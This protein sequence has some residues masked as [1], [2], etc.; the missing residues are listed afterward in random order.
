MPTRIVIECIGSRG[1]VEPYIALGAGLVQAGYDVAVAT[2]DEFEE[3]V[4]TNAMEHRR[5]A[6]NPSEVV[7]TALGT[8]WQ[9]SRKNPYL[10]ASRLKELSRSLFD[11]Y[12][13]DS[14]VAVEDADAVVFSV[15]GVAAYHVAEAKG[16]PAVAAWLQPFTRTSAFPNP[17]ITWLPA[18]VSHRIFEQIMWQFIRRETNAFRSR[19]GVE[20]HPFFGP[21]EQL[22][23]REM[24]IL[25]GF[26]PTIVPRPADWPGYVHVTGAW[27]RDRN[28]PLA[29]D[30]EAF[31]ADGPPPVYIGFGS[32][33]DQNAE[34]TS[35]EV[36][37]AL[38]M[39]GARAIVS[40]GWGGLV[41]VDGPDVL[42]V[43]ETNHQALFP[44]CSAIVHHGGAGTTHTA[45]RSGMPSVVVPHWAD[46]FFWADRI[47]VTGAGPSSVSRDSLTADALAIRIDEA[48]SKHAQRAGVVGRSMAA[49]DGVATAVGHI[50][51]ILSQA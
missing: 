28:D 49:E 47:A 11:E 18:T 37:R 1:D 30:L 23:D 26:S 5:V 33:S 31:L 46:Q 43:G 32:R 7:K 25:Y 34:Q 38:H 27:F 22:A 45:A 50:E 9:D 16:V 10:M 42:S 51:R 17:M 21:Y 35:S 24:P 48:V 41:N 12:L 39:L 3:L 13:E 15:L 6:G 8:S 19:L 14:L 20:P 29:D 2:H 4:S 44:R 40:D 36:S